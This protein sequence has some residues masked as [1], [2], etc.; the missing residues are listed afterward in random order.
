MAVIARSRDFDSVEAALP[1]IC[2]GQWATFT[3]D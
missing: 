1:D 3:P 2:D